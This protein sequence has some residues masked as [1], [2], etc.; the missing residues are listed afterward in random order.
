MNGAPLTPHSQAKEDL[1][2]PGESAQLIV[3]TCQGIPADF[4]FT[5]RACLPGVFRCAWRLL[6]STGRWRKR[7]TKWDS[8]G[9]LLPVA[10]SDPPSTNPE[11]SAWLVFAALLALWGQLYFAAIPIWRYGEYYSF[12]WFVPPLAVFLFI[13]RWGG[14]EI[15][16]SSTLVLWKLFVL[17]LMLLPVLAL[18]RAVAA[19]DPSWRPALLLQ[20]L[21]VTG[22]SHLILYWWGGWKWTFGM[23]PVTI[24][25]LTAMPY[26]WQFEQMLIRKLTG[27]VIVI[28]G[29]LFNLGGRPVTVIGEKL[30]SMGTVVEVT[31]GCSGIRSFQNLIMAALFFGELFLLGLFPRVLLLGVAVLASVVVN[32]ARAMT[33][34]RIRFDEGDAAFHAAHDSVGYIS[35]AVCA[36]VLL[37]SAKFLSEFR[38]GKRRLVRTNTVAA[39]N[40]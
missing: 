35:F 8:S 20:A 27:G 22:A 36:L 39:S 34:A 11:S 28:A 5:S 21:M 30:E 12:G 9:R 2:V 40:P 26:P 6:R 7:L 23:V 25:A 10:A 14:M 15:P 24:Y 38:G 29:E 33:L 19:F 4:P 17:A 32:T 1:G 3:G 31:E 18:I 37:V 16:R 13:R